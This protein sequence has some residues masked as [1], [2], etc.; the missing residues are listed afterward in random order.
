MYYKNQ[1]SHNGGV[2]SCTVKWVNRSWNKQNDNV[3]IFYYNVISFGFNVHKGVNRE[4][5]NWWDCQKNLVKILSN[6]LIWL[7]VGVRI[8]KAPNIG[9]TFAAS[10][11]Q[12]Y[13]PFKSSNFSSRPSNNISTSCLKCCMHLWWLNTL[14]CIPSIFFVLSTFCTVFSVVLCTI[15]F[16]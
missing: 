5:G 12:W 15:C 14:Y 3:R 4:W 6:F 9:L 10:H 11:W 2:V 8:S 1:N 13:C 16:E 7:D